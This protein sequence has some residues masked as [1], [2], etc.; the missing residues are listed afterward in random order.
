[1]LN[2]T[3]MSKAQCLQN[4]FFPILARE[5]FSHVDSQKIM[6]SFFCVLVGDGEVGMPNTSALLIQSICRYWAL[7][8]GGF[9]R[10]IED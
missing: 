6:R 10:G 9:A 8:A 7:A 1:M 5:T 2:L 3:P 4:Y